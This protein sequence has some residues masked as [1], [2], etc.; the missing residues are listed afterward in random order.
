MAT[1]DDLIIP[2]TDLSQK[3][4][5]DFIRDL[6]AIRRIKPESPKAYRK[7]TKGTRGAKAKVKGNLSKLKPAE[8]AR[9]LTPEQKLKLLREM[10][11]DV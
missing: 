3:D 10:G 6:R 11:V 4:A 1:I 8:I 7:S 5:Y 9:I 2:F